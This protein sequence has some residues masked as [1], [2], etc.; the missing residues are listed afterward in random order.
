[1]QNG[2]MREGG[3]LRLKLRKVWN[4]KLYL[5]WDHYNQEYLSG[6]LQR[7][8]IRIG[9]GE[10]ELGQWNGR[11]RVLT[12]SAGHIERDPWGAVMETLRHE[13]AHQ[14][15]QETLK[16]R[17][18]G[19]HGEAFRKACERLRCSPG[20]RA[21]RPELE[22]S[23]EGEDARVLR[24]L[25][26]VLSLAGSPNEHEAQA[27]VQKAR[28]LLAKYNVDLVALDRER[29]FGV[30]CL[31]EVK[32]RHPSYELWLSSILATSFFV[33]VLWS[34]SYD[35]RRDRMGTVLEVY[36]T[37]ANLEM[38]DYVYTYLLNLLDRLWADY[39][40][41]KGLRGNRERQRF[42]AGVLEGFYRKLKEQEQTLQE[43]H[44]LVWTGDSQ[45]Q[46]FYRYINPRVHTRSGGK[47]TRTRAYDDG[48]QEGR[49]VTIHRPVAE[50]GTGSGGYLEGRERA[51][52]EMKNEK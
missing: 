51:V 40:R 21:R 49:K 33:E 2:K 31:G 8:A 17:D 16:A 28:Y 39:R 46:A 32:G 35:A 29:A 4:R 5:W 23:P 34:H 43:T 45:L 22:G 15:A 18:D 11:R 50:K 48:V 6:V 27:A 13:M 42:F 7:P 25:K 12:V 41:A 14:Y 1:M 26:K 20:A 24:V 9:E 36:G 37:P 3:A 38:A 30:R 10:G 44:A 19:P 47:V 52:G